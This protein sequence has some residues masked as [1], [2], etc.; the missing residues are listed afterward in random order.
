MSDLDAIFRAERGRVLASL[1]RLLG[2]FEL[3]EEALADAFLAAATQWPRDGVP[4]NPRAWLVSAGRFKAIDRLRR[5]GRFRQALPELTRQADS[6]D[7]VQPEPQEIEDDTLRLV[8][9]CCHPALPADAQI[10]L[11]LREVCGLTTEEIAAAFLASPAA[12][13]QRIVRAKAKIR[14]EHLPYEVPPPAEWPARLDAVLH[15]VYLIFNEGYSASRGD[16]LI[17]AEL[18]A[19]AIRL[20]RLL[21]DLHPSPD[22]D[23][24]LGLMVL[25]QSRAAARIDAEGGIVLLED[26]DRTLWDRTLMAEGTTLAQLAFASPPVGAY[27]IQAMIAATHAS[28]LEPG[29]TDWGRIVSLYDLLLVADPSPVVALNRAVAIAMRDG[30]SAGL[31]LIDALLADG[32]LT[33]YRFAPAARADLLRRLGRNEEAKAAY[34]RALDLAQQGAER[35]FLTSRIEATT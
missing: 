17:R 30:P 22:V 35:A 15:V 7:N 25:H 3:A 10:A 24:L 23:G 19:E 16:G 31:A 4:A 8:L 34:Q 20:A 1:I 12:I 28:A 21:K 29:D 26:Q 18:A 32:R 14:D 33:A 11:T 5:S 2:G 27:T 6:E 9:V 13:A